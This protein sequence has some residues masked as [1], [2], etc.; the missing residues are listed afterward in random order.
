MSDATVARFEARWLARQGVSAT[1]GE[2]EAAADAQAAMMAEMRRPPSTA[3]IDLAERAVAR[4]VASVMA[5]PEQDVRPLWAEVM[6]LPPRARLAAWEGLH[7][8][9]AMFR[10]RAA[11]DTGP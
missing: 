9:H 2:H 1:M 10:R 8:A 7:D 3:D 4:V 11:L 5:D 6:S